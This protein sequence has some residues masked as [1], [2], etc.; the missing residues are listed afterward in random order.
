MN[1]RAQVT[2]ETPAHEERLGLQVRHLVD[3]TVTDG[4]ADA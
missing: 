3:A 1:F 4:A 2:V